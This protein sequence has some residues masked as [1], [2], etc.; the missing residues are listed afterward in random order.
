MAS[1]DWLEQAGA[2]P[3]LAQ[4][5]GPARERIAEL[6]LGVSRVLDLEAGDILIQEG[7]LGGTAGYILVHGQVSVERRGAPEVRLDSPA[8]LGEMQQFNPQEQRTATVTA[9]NNGVALKFGWLDL[10]ARAKEALSEDEQ[11]LLLAAIERCVWERFHEEVLLDL[12]LL[13][14]LPDQ[15]RLQICILLHWLAQPVTARAGETLFV[16]GA[17]CGG[18]G[19]LLIEGKVALLAGGQTLG[20][21]QAPSILGIFP[22]F[23]PDASWTATARATEGVSALKFNWQALDL[24]LAQWLSAQ[25]REQFRTALDAAQ[26][27]D[28]VH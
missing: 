5:P 6:F 8:L 26:D 25:G 19:Y 21:V 20:Q 18:H 17:T 4:V 7:A 12:P 11:H 24:L 9:E 28:F 27:R 1:S 14:G 2:L 15:L 22:A 23:D 10:Y 16:Q 3:L 13:R